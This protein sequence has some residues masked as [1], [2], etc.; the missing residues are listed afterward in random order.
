MSSSL[1]RK[2]RPQTEIPHFFYGTQSSSQCSYESISVPHHQPIYPPINA[3]VSSPEVTLYAYLVSAAVTL[4][5]I[6]LQCYTVN[7]SYNKLKYNIKI[8]YINFNF[9]ITDSCQQLLAVHTSQKYLYLPDTSPHNNRTYWHLYHPA[10]CCQTHKTDL[11]FHKNIMHKRD[12]IYY[13]NFLFS[14]CGEMKELWE[15]I[16][17]K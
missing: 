8:Y 15:G 16:S 10:H 9:I 13:S 5:N 12:M 6:Q 3:Q 1:G 4:F 17:M 7:S 11:L 2:L 14:I